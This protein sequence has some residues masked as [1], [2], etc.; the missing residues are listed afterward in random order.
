MDDGRHFNTPD[1]PRNHRH[2]HIG[3]GGEKFSWERDDLGALKW[4]YLF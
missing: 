4:L 2:V 3:G 1:V